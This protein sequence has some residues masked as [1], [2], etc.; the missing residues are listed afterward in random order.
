MIILGEQIPCIKDN[1]VKFCYRCT[2]GQYK[3]NRKNLT[4]NK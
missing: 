1:F 3:Y 2:A 4:T